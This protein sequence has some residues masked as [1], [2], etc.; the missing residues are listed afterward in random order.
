MS[1]VGCSGEEFAQVLKELGFHR[2]RKPIETP[3]MPAG[4]TSGAA[5]SEVASALPD[6]EAEPQFDEIWRPRRRK[7][8]DGAERK[9]RKGRR[10]AKAPGGKRQPG[11]GRKRDG[12]AGKGAPRRFTAG[13]PKKQT[14]DP[15][16]PFAALKD[17]KRDL[18][19][20]VKE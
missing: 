10:A 7:P 4:T 11:K 19:S 14:A 16:S 17:L 6:A 12:A 18:E 20:R 9:P 5:D 3:P 1:I 15:D 13:P 2:E 8:R